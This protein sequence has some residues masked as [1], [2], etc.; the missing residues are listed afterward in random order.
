LLPG[1]FY[2]TGNNARLFCPLFT[3]VLAE[4][5]VQLTHQAGFATGD[6]VVMQDA[7]RGSPVQRANRLLGHFPSLL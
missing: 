5:L 7:F 1:L 3:Q 6:I 4:R 2:V